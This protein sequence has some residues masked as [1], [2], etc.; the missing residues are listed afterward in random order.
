MAIDSEKIRGMM[1]GKTLNKQDID[2]MCDMVRKAEDP[3]EKKK[4]M[5]HSVFFVGQLPLN[6]DHSVDVKQTMRILRSN[7]SYEDAQA[8]YDSM[9]DAL[10]TQKFLLKKGEDRYEINSKYE[11]TVVKARKIAR[12][13]ELGEKAAQDEAMPDARKVYQTG[14]K[15]YRNGQYEEA[16]D[17]FRKAV[18]MAGH[19]M[20]YYSLALMYKEGKGVDPSLNDALYYVS[21]ALAKGA[22]IAEP[23]EQEILD[24]M[25]R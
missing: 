6:E 10:T 11:N 24:Q 5:K 12:A 23:L 25:D 18:D 15:Y 16:A 22:R 8:C 17:A 3:E 19:R 9:M 7:M 2:R 4:V 13:Y 20:A 1:K 14:T 21:N